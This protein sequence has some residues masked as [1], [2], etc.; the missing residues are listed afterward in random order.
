MFLGV[1]YYLN[2]S[3]LE[4]SCFLGRTKKEI[5]HALW[6]WRMTHNCLCEVL[7]S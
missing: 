6:G 4:N 5:V 7:T 3:R 2:F 1:I